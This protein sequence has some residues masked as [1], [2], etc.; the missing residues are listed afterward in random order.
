MTAASTQHL[1]HACTSSGSSSPCGQAH[2]SSSLRSRHHSPV[3]PTA[4][5]SH[6]YHMA[7]PRQSSQ[8]PVSSAARSETTMPHSSAELERTQDSQYTDMPSSQPN[9]TESA[10]R[11]HQPQ[12]QAQQQQQSIASGSPSAQQQRQ[13]QQVRLPTAPQ[14]RR[15]RELATV[16]LT[17]ATCQACQLPVHDPVTLPCGHSSC[18]QCIK[19]RV[20]PKSIPPEE[21]VKP[22]PCLSHLPPR[23][24][25]S[26]MTVACPAHGCPRSAIGRGIGAWAGHQPRYGL[27]PTYT[28][29]LP[30]GSEDVGPGAPPAD[31]FVMGVADH[32]LRLTVV[33]PQT[34]SKA[35]LFALPPHGVDSN[36]ATAAGPQQMAATLLPSLATSNL[37]RP[38]VTLSKAVAILMRYASS[39]PPRPPRQRCGAAGSSRPSSS[40]SS[41]SRYSRPGAARDTNN[42]S[43]YSARGRGAVRSRRSLQSR[44]TARALAAAAP[45]SAAASSRRYHPSGMS[46]AGM[47][48]FGRNE[49]DLESGTVG[50][51]RA[52]YESD[53]QHIPADGTFVDDS[54]D[55][56]SADTAH[57]RSTPHGRTHSM[58]IQVDRDQDK[59]RWT[60]HAGTNEERTEEEDDRLWPDHVGGAFSRPPLSAAAICRRDK[61]RLKRRRG[62]GSDDSTSS[63]AASFRKGNAAHTEGKVAKRDPSQSVEEAVGRHVDSA[64]S[65]GLHGEHASEALV[66]A[67]RRRR[68]QQALGS[69]S[70]AS[71]VE[72]DADADD[73]I[74]R[75]RNIEAKHSLALSSRVG[76]NGEPLIQTVATLHSELAEV[77]ECQL[78]YLLLY[79]PLTTPCGHTFCK[80]CFAR[81]LDHGDRCPLCRADMPN[82]SF[83]QDH[84][85]N[86]ALLKILTSDTATFSDEDG[87]LSDSTQDA[88]HVA[89]NTYAG[90]SIAM[91][92]GGDAAKHVH[93]ASRRAGYMIDDD[94]ETAPHHYGFKRLYEQR[95]AAIQQEEREARLSTPIF[96]CTLAFPGMPTILH[97]FEPR[98]RLMVRRCLESGNPR[99]GMVLPSRNNG[100]TEEYGTMLEIKSVQMLADGR[101]MLETVGSYRFRLLEKGS[102]DGY[103]VGRVERVDDISLEEE[104]ELER[105]VLMRRAELDKKK[106]A[107]AVE[108]PRS[109]PMSCSSSA[110]V[111]TVPSGSNEAEEQQA[112][113]TRPEMLRAES[114]ALSNYRS[115][116]SAPQHQ[117]DWHPEDPDAITPAADTATNNSNTAPEEQEQEQEE[118]ILPFK[119]VPA[120]PSIEELTEIC[121]SFIETLRSGSAPW[122]LSRLNHTYGPMP[123]ADQV[124]RLGYW[125]ALVMPIDEHE[126]AKLLPIRSRRSRLCLVVHWIEQLRQSWWFNSGCT[127]S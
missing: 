29:R 24:P 76:V 61:A 81:S 50:G 116:P 15:A 17:L 125:M 73:A 2:A 92:S 118:G 8:P 60:V 85:P 64:V 82:F 100:G 43:A 19:D 30:V 28:E 65:H 109:Q 4:P 46:Q 59:E 42:Q 105:S 26:P 48:I 40:S 78:C 84:R 80:S 110:P 66:D 113:L 93:D 91:G 69:N 62:R 35:H 107:E 98:Y 94:P 112:S 11:Q 102:L 44:P 47:G 39:P 49:S 23:L 97:I 25:L 1:Q 95:K 117:D 34:R 53:N 58:H 99:F 3:S 67:V 51:V 96:V 27:I 41:R 68:A 37:L 123:S 10:T 74:A 31:G 5:A 71:K 88:K 124:E 13:P 36:S 87:M 111:R 83:F 104:A 20:L 32:P 79:D 86:T 54:D 16:L 52:A 108:P 9:T 45:S 22:L 114:N 56:P 89:P 21:Q 120:E 7:A 18:L 38:D 127:V 122:L 90:I 103:T 75:N 63:A 6:D 121:T 55:D 12:Q 101:S 33:G 57:Q 126:K 14:R 106:A 115:D 119:P 72:T 70:N 77:L